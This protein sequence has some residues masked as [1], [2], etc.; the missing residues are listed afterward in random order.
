MDNYDSLRFILKQNVMSNQYLCVFLFSS[1]YVYLSTSAVLFLLLSISLSLS[2]ARSLNLS[3]AFHLVYTQNRLSNEEP[4][5]QKLSEREKKTTSPIHTVNAR[6]GR[7]AIPD[8]CVES[9]FAVVVA[10]AAVFIMFLL[11]MSAI[12]KRCLNY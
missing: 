2:I 1:L 10:A 3:A 5:M 9:V 8:L 11:L 7:C 4:E 6:H 12:N